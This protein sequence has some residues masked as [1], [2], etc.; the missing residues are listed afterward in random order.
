MMAL[1]DRFAACQV[2]EADAQYLYQR[3]Y[4]ISTSRPSTLGAISERTVSRPQVWASAAARTVAGRSA[5]S[6]WTRCTWRASRSC[7]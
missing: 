5:S 2:T 1:A 6:A 4:A 7:R 3:S